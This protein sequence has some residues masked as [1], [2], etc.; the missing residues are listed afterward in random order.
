MEVLGHECHRGLDV[1]IILGETH[2]MDLGMPNPIK[3]L[4]ITVYKSPGY[5]PGPVST[6]IKEDN[7]ITILNQTNRFS[8]SSTTT[9]GSINSSV[10]S[11]R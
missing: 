8:L 4:E 10:V 2:I 1:Y 3:T 6:E 9:V 7:P 5:L 11:S